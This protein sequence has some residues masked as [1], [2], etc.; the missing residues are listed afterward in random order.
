MNAPD[1]FEYDVAFSFHSLDE[2]TAVQ[3]NDRLRGRYLTFLYSE[4]QKTVAGRDGEMI[5]NEVFRNKAR[6]VAVL[7]RKEWGE[8]PFT[9][10]EQRAI[11]NRAYEQG[12]GFT[13]FI[14]TEAKPTMPPWVERTRLYFSLERFG[15]DGAAAVIESKLQELGVAPT[16]EGAKERAVRLQRSLDFK[17]QKEAFDKTSAGAEAGAQSFVSIMEKIKAI[18]EEIARRNTALAKLTMEQ[19]GSWVLFGLG[20]WLLFN[21]TNRYSNVLDDAHLEADFYYNQPRLL[22]VFNFGDPG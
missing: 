8:T 6:F 2:G 5:F 16:I 15:I 7:Y 3:I 17:H 4:H 11:R 19:H 10:I 9:L 21:W 14:P 22:G 12:Y 18:V 1:D 20:P 13:L